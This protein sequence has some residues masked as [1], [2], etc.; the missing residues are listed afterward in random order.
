MGD[1]LEKRFGVHAAGSSVRTEIL[2]GIATF[3]AMAY[4][5]FVNPDILSKAGMN[6]DA[7]FVATCLAAAIGT[8]LMGVLANKPIALAPGMG[9]NAFFAF[10]VVP[11]AGGSW[12]IALA[13]VFISGVLFF[14]LSVTP[15]REWLINTIPADLKYGIAA[16][17]GL[18][19]AII[20][21]RGAGLVGDH[22]ATLVTLGDLS[23]MTTLLACAGFLVIAVLHTLR[24]PG[25]II[26]GVLGVTVA[27]VLMGLQKFGGIASLPPSI[28]PTLF[29]LDVMGT[30]LDAG[31]A[32][33]LT[34]LTII[35]T[36][37][38]VDLLDTAGTLIA[39]SEHGDMLDENGKVENLRPALIADSG[40]TVI[41]ALLGTSTTTSYIESA[42]GINEGGRTGLT[43]VVV[44]ILFLLAL[45]FAPLAGTVPSY[46][47]APALVFVAALMASGLGKMQWSDPTDYVPAVLTAVMMPFT[48]S[49]ATGIGIGFVA[50]TLLKLITG[51]VT[52]INPAVALIAAFFIASQYFG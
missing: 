33:K 37:L 46:A 36:F 11:A 50:H 7:V 32:L 6:F 15:F 21:L 18:F 25:A 1:F 38:L 26:I 5:V 41:G 20:G 23:S 9:L 40:S 35:F 29:Q 52:E 24:V 30:V 10:A 13:C 47:T 28:S 14:L 39:V 48:Y 12:Q 44:A 2:A 8:A 19:L 22:P 4:I 51:K 17:I 3:L 45:F 34:F 31:G 27:A 16:G 49:I 43:A 42:A